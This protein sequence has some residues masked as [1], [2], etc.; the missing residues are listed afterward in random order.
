MANTYI[1]IKTVTVGAAGSNTIDLTAIPGSYTD[2]ILS[3]KLRSNR[4]GV[5]D[6]ILIRF[7]GVTSGYT[8][9]F[10]YGNAA[11]SYAGTD[12]IASAFQV[13]AANGN[14]GTSNTFGNSA[15]YIPNYTSSTDKNIVSQAMFANDTATSEQSRIQ[16]YVGKF[17]SSSAITQIS[18]I[19]YFGTGF[20]QYSVATLYG[21]K[22]T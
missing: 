2:L 22:S 3:Y 17:T 5:E 1:P 18:L 10:I 7:N 11:G 6:P 12:T 13:F 9:R 14:T 8:G 16:T 4:S 15:F 20:V 19:P 21:I